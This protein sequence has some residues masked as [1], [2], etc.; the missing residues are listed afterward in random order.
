MTN[1]LTATRLEFAEALTN[2]GLTIEVVPFIPGRITPPVAI[3][4][5]A[6]NYVRPDLLRAEWRLGLEVDLI[7]ATADNELADEELDG[8]IC[9]FVAALPAYATLSSVSAPTGL[10]TGNADYLAATASVEINM[11]LER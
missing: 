8:L 5:P 6:S 10:T 2:A 11:T 1:E 4:R 3:I 9:D 7:A